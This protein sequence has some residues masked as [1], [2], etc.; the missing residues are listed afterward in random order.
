M[1]NR[2]DNRGANGVNESRANPSGLVNGMERYHDSPRGRQR[3]GSMRHILLV[4]ISLVLASGPASQASPLYKNT[5]IGDNPQNYWRLGETSGTTAFDT[6]GNSNGTYYNSPTLGVAGAITNDPGHTAVSFYNAG[7]KYMGATINC[8]NSFSIEVWAMAQNGNQFWGAGT[9]MNTANKYFDFGGSGSGQIIFRMNS[10]ADFLGY[11]SGFTPTNGYQ[12]W[13]QYVATYDHTSGYGYL[14]VDG[15]L[16]VNNGGW[17][18]KVETNPGGTTV[19]SFGSSSYGSMDDVSYYNY[20]LTPAQV[21][22][23]YKAAFA[24]KTGT[25]IMFR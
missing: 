21:L 14:Y 17:T 24:I 8:N 19:A 11:R 4:A 20:A 7:S 2:T 5:I 3:K 18:H 15:Q 12:T 13:H 22:T 25:G 16:V 1:K 6:M 10:G 9:F 23:H